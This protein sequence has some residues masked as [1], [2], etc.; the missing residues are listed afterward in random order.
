MATIWV[1]RDSAIDAKWERS[2][3]DRY[4]VFRQAGQ[5]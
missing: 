2:A 4:N 5:E 1:I 3:D